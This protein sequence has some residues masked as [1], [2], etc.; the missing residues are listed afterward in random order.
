LSMTQ[1]LIL[2]GDINLMGVTNPKEPFAKVADTLKKADAVF[3]NLECC[4]YDSPDSA[5]SQQEWKSA[6]SQT[7]QREGFHVP[8]KVAEALNIAGISAIGNANN[9]NFGDEAIKSSNAVLDGYGIPHTGSGTNREAALKSAIVKTKKL[10]YGMVQRTSVYWPSTHE[11]TEQTP[12]VAAMKVHTAYRPLVDEK[13]ANRPGVPPEILTWADPA[14]L[15]DFIK[16]IKALKKKCDIAIASIHWGYDGKVYAYQEEI[17]KALI[18]A[19]AD[20]IMGHGPHEP[21]AVATYKKKPIFY[22]MGSFSFKQGHRGRKHPDWV[23]LMARVTLDGRKIKKTSIQFVRHNE[24][25]ETLLKPLKAEA[26]SLDMMQA[27]S[28]RFGTKFKAKGDELVF[29]ENK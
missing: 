3:S 4:F 2:T 24:K 8:A 25:N 28:E 1:T 16:Q 19:G 11:A 26:G 29:L 27:K 14:Y 13:A 20:I 9:V 23:G 17:A 12:G 22:G 18:D 15:Q 21:L 7:L 10:R 5:P 6:G